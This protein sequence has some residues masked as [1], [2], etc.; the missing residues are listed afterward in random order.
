MDAD[1]VTYCLSKD[2]RIK[3]KGRIVASKKS[4]FQE[5]TILDT[6]HLGRVLLLGE[7]EYA[8][9]QFATRDEPLYHE[10]IVH[11]TMGLHP[12]PKKVLVVGGGD[13]GTIR[14]VLKHPVEKVVLAELD[15]EVIKI[16]KEFFPSLSDGAFEDPRLEIRLGDGRRYV[17]DTDE[18]F[19]VAILDLTDAEGPATMLF[20]KE[21]YEAVRSKLTEGGVISVQT[22]SPIYEP[23]QNGRVHATLKGLFRNVLSYGNFV[24]TYFIV[25]SYVIATD[26]PV[27]GIAM[28]LKQRDVKLRAYTPEQLE[29]M[30]LNPHPFVKEN[31][32]KEW[33]I[34]TDEDPLDISGMR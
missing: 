13:G 20:T 5:I 22:G 18:R 1:E 16:S 23:K 21:F 15:D 6:E 17:E 29:F 28:R 34:S 14:E 25:E 32:A 27:G 19:D 11:P 33:K 7:G 26:S 31:I 3:L 8:I 10:A 30:A 4:R 9:T 24:Q 2:V 12:E